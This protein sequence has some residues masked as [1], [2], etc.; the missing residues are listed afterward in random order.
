MAVISVTIIQ[1]HIQIVS[2]IPKTVSITTNIPSTIFYT[3]DGTIPTL[4]SMMY[5][6]TIFLPFDQLQ[7]VLSV[8][9]TNGTISSP[10]VVETYQTN[11]VS[12]NVRL[13]HASTT[14]RP[15]S[16]IPNTYPFGNPPYQ[17]DQKFLNPAKS[18]VTVYNPDLPATPTEFDAN[19]NPA[20]FTNEPY[21][22]LNY[23]IIY[24]DKNA[25]G[26]Q[27]HGIGNLVP[28]TVLTPPAPPEESNQFTSTFDP[29]ALVIFQDFRSEDPSDP[30]QI[31][32]QYFTLE[33]PERARDGTFF[34][35]TGVD[36]TAPPSGAFI[37]AHYNPREGTITHYYRD[38]W[39]NRWIIST[40]A[41]VPSGNFD[42]NMAAM[43]TN[44][45]GRIFEW[46]PHAR[47]IL[48]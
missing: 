42:G 36:A 32:R 25:E 15:G 40:S 24:N 31:N 26:E 9:A 3:L 8:L 4:N 30:P 17:P 16:N 11:I 5:T 6:G 14:A 12:G 19:G 44:W 22:S 38:S 39:T 18:G 48:F 37:R 41:Y 20:G 46:I 2:G 45:G 33:D 27:G 43:A 13:P 34:F 21:N 29:K 35:N 10:I 7:V 1:S 47:R 28:V 23:Q